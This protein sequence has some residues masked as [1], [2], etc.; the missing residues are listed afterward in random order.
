MTVC[1]CRISRGNLTLLFLMMTCTRLTM[2]LGTETA[3]PFIPKFWQYAEVSNIHICIAWNY[4][5]SI[6]GHLFRKQSWS[7]SVRDSKQKRYIKIDTA[8]RR[9]FSSVY[10][11]TMIYWSFFCVSDTTKQPWETVRFDQHFA[12]TKRYV[13]KNKSNIHAY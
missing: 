6:L 10:V 12:V 3:R 4:N 2:A 11:R 13:A 7:I 1:W 5:V 9:F 8:F